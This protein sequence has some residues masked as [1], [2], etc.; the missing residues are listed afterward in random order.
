MIWA[1]LIAW[2]VVDVVVWTNLYADINALRSVN[3]NLIYQLDQE[4]RKNERSGL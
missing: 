3:G 4:R 1:L 2:I